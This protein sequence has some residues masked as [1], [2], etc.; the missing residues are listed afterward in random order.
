MA[1]LDPEVD[2]EIAAWVRSMGIP[3]SM[4]AVVA[5]KGICLGRTVSD[6][7]P[8]MGRF[9]GSAHGWFAWL[10]DWV[11]SVLP[12]ANL[13]NFVWTSIQINFNTVSRWHA[14][15]NNEGPSMIAT[16]GEY[17]SSEFPVEAPKR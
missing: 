16:A 2:E 6:G 5:G 14:D 3:Y 4:R 12:E 11:L 9:N 8:V 15:K 10:N 1:D 13:R 17:E 7:K